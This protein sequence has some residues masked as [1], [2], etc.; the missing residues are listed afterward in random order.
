MFS[1]KPE[2]GSAKKALKKTLRM[3]H[4]TVHGTPS[5][6]LPRP[7]EEAC[8]CVT[9][10]VVL[11]PLGGFKDYQFCA[12]LTGPHLLDEDLHNQSC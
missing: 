4:V 5:D 12:L 1:V 9:E 8:L 3:P 10:P 11:K 2:F 6:I 7:N